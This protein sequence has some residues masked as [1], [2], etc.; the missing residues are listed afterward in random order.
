MR[1]DAIERTINDTMFTIAEYILQMLERARKQQDMNMK[2]LLDQEMKNLK[3]DYPSLTEEERG[4]IE[5]ELYYSLVKE[6]Q[7]E[8]FEVKGNCIES[9]PVDK[10][11]GVF[12]IY[13]DKDTYVGVYKQDG[14][15]AHKITQVFYS[16][17]E[18]LQNVFAT[19]RFEK[20]KGRSLFI[21]EDG[22]SFSL[23]KNKQ[24]RLNLVNDRKPAFKT[25]KN[26][27]RLRSSIVKDNLKNDPQ[28]RKKAFRRTL[29]DYYVPTDLLGKTITLKSIEKDNEGVRMVLEENQKERELNLP[30][31][32]EKWIEK[33]KENPHVK[34]GFDEIVMDSRSIAEGFLAFYGIEINKELQT[35]KHDFEVFSNEQ[36]SYIGKLNGNGTVNKVSPYFSEKEAE[37]QLIDLNKHIQ[38]EKEKER[39]GDRDLGQELEFVEISE[40]N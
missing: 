36:G 8:L 34:A 11:K 9:F 28:L 16:K 32:A 26:I 22:K 5:Y 29:E 10:A 40:E 2:M 18:V 24:F 27:E 7:P 6:R 38:L 19:S 23:D 1:N 39:Q 12:Q 20:F 3:K 37:K 25:H 35:K 21:Q 31:I 4:E 13:Q 17:E 30:D 33:V 15:E 14:K